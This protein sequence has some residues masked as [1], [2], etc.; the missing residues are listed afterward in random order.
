MRTS[1]STTRLFSLKVTAVVPPAITA[2]VSERCGLC[3]DEKALIIP[4]SFSSMHKK[5]VLEETRWSGLFFTTPSKSCCSFGAGSRSL[6]KVYQPNS[7]TLPWHHL[8]I[9]ERTETFPPSITHTRR[10]RSVIKAIEETKTLCY[11][12]NENV[13]GY[14]FCQ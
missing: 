7:D 6:L 3:V 9:G 1:A 8:L 5:H 14:P 11:N 13:F 4:L 12:T 10:G 2:A